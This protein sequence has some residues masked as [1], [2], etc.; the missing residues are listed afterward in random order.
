MVKGNTNLIKKINIYNIIKILRSNPGVSRAD[1]SK[2]TKLTPASITKITKELIEKG[3]LFEGELSENTLGRPSISLKINKE[4]GYF[5]GFYLAPKHII[6]FFTNY[7]GEVISTLE[8]KILD[9]SKNSILNIIDIHIESFKK[10]NS[11]ILG[12]GIALNGV[13]DSDKGIS[14][15]SPHYNWKNF[16]LKKFL[17][18]KYHYPFSLDN[19][20]RLMALG[21]L[22]HGAA[23]G[24]NNFILI[25]IN[26]GIGAGI[27]IDKKIYSGSQHFAGEIGHIKVSEEN[28]LCSCGK[29]GC[30]ES[31]LSNENTINLANNKYSLNIKDFNDLKNEFNNKNPQCELLVDELINKLSSVI[32]P[33]VNLLNPNIILI[34]GNINSLGKDFYKKL[35]LKLNNNSIIKIKIKPSKLGDSSASLGA[36]SMIF[37]DIYK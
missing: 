4:A 25:N 24:E 13:V 14:I 12:V 17:T 21:E 10:M 16:G 6:S 18:E 32:L 27:I 2:I 29:T 36:V 20:V 34:N 9:F 11:N 15:F 8:T 5:I 33:T 23:K 22:E 35:T 28:T 1:I 30:L 3:I 7:I 37:N 31:F 19:D 26:D